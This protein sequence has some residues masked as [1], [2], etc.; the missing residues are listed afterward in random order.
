MVQDFDVLLFSSENIITQEL[1]DF[2]YCLS[3]RESRKTGV[4]VRTSSVTFQ[5]MNAGSIENVRVII[6]STTGSTVS[7]QRPKQTQK[8]LLAIFSP[9]CRAVESSAPCYEK[10]YLK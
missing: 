3:L 5:R 6:A 8:P 10:R 2:F 9:S 4:Y 7:T 1:R